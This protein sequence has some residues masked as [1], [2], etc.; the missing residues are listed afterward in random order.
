MHLTYQNCPG[1][2]KIYKPIN[3]KQWN[4]KSN[5]DSPVPVILA[6]LV[7]EIKNISVKAS[8]WG[9]GVR[10]NLSEPKKFGC[11]GMHLLSQWMGSVKSER[12][13]QNG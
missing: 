13:A 12:K 1:E 5:K 6:I 11:G 2:Y 7:A 3:N 10:E 9:L 8:L 4:L